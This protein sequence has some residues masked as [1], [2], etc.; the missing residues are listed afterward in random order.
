MGSSIFHVSE[1]PITRAHGEMSVIS[2]AHRDFAPRRALAGSPGAVLVGADA[3]I[4]WPPRSHDHDGAR[5]K[6]AT[7]RRGARVHGVGTAV[8]PHVDQQPSGQADHHDL[9]GQDLWASADG[10]D[11]AAFL[12]EFCRYHVWT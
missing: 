6:G 9:S 1:I 11:R 8:R 10:Y 2:D 12:F 7:R 4:G 5:G 3:V